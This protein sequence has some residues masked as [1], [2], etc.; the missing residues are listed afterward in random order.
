MVLTK[1]WGIA[2][3]VCVACAMGRIS[4]AQDTKPAVDEHQPAISA[5]INA[6]AHRLLE[7]GLKTSALTG[8]DLKPFHLKVDFQV[9]EPRIPKP[10]SGSV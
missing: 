9:I 5:K 8:D 1:K 6:L 2:L 3:P 10:V 7:S 4:F